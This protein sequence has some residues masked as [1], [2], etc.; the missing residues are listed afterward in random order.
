YRDAA[1]FASQKAFELG[2]TTNA[3]LLHKNVYHEIRSLF[4]LPSQIACSV[5]R[6]V[7][8]AYKTLWSRAASNK[9][10]RAKGWTKRLFK[11]LDTAPKF[12]E[13]TVPYQYHY[14]YAFKA[15]QQVS[16]M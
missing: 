3:N 12:R 7:T 4:D 1:N 15:N 16:V 11:G 2:K 14:D 10:A 9:K 6:Y 13:R 8:A 5:S